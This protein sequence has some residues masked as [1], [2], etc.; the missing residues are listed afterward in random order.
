MADAACN[1]GFSRAPLRE[2]DGIPVFCETDRYTTNYERVA[3]DHLA[4]MRPGV[5]NPFIPDELWKTLDSSTRALVERHTAP[6]GS[7]L[8]VGVGLGR[9]L[10]PLTQYRRFGVDLS[11]DYL[12]H[13]GEAGIEVACAR[14]E[15]LP[16]ADG[17][18]DTV[19]TAD[20]LEHVFDLNLALRELIRVLK[21]GGCLI[22]R[23][24]NKEDLEVYLRDD[25]PYEFIHL[26]AFDL[27]GLRLLLAKVFG[28]AF[29]EG[30]EV[31]PH[32][33]GAPRLRLRLLPESLREA[34]RSL[35]RK[36]WLCYWPI[37]AALALSEEGFLVW[38][39]RVQRR[40]PDRYREIAP[41]V[42]MGIEFNAVFRKAGR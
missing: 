17:V 21:P 16:F 35:A 41:V 6:G 15:S 28:M 20:V 8:D 9:V 26:R 3:L 22:I 14:A 34:A 23:V 24:P 11:L 37:R 36:H 29:V 32:L 10:G 38:L 4:A 7:V 18:F 40:W 27:H 31:G 30:A 33:Q 12:R 2:V 25:L 42:I 19:I 1:I 5:D 13:A 39:N